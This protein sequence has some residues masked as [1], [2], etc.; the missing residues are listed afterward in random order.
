MQLTCTDGYPTETRATLERITLWD[1]W[2]SVGL[3]LIWIVYNV[4]WY[5]S[6]QHAR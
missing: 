4:F 5:V 3:G 1:F 6:F 2:F